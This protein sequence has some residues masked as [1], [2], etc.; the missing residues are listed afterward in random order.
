MKKHKVKIPKGYILV[1]ETKT[2]I[3]GFMTI[4]LGLEPTPTEVPIKK[5]LS[6]TWDE[7]CEITE[8]F[9]KDYNGQMTA[10]RRLIEL[11]D[12]YNDGWVP[13]WKNCSNKYCIFNRSGT[14]MDITEGVICHILVFKTDKLRDKFHLNF[15][16]LIEIAKPLL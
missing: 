12:Y 3:D 9:K 11:R 6:K 1:N 5:E 15:T 10:L 8:P 7:Y 16:E 4:T 14:I 13:N 2:V